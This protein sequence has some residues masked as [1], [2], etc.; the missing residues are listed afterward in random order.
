[1]NTQNMRLDKY[2]H[3]LYIGYTIIKAWNRHVATQRLLVTLTSA[4]DINIS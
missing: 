2:L 1:M 4:S 3:L